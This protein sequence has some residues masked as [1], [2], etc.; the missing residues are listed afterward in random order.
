M[1]RPEQHSDAVRPPRSHSLFVGRRWEIDE[2]RAALDEVANGAGQI[3]LLAGE[4]G[5][6]KTRLVEEIVASV[7]SHDIAVY[8]GR[9]DDWEGS[10]AYWPWSQ[11]LSPIVETVDFETLTSWMGG[12]AALLAQIVPGVAGPRELS[13]Q[14]PPRDSEQ[15]RFELFSAVADLVRN[16]AD[17]RPLILV[18][19]DLHWADTPSLELFRFLVRSIRDARIMLLATYRPSEAGRDT[20]LSA[21]LGSMAREHGHRR[22]TLHGL[23]RDEVAAFVSHS[24]QNSP[25]KKLVDA[26][27]GTVDGNPFFMRE[28]VRL[29]IAES[30]VDPARI[31]TLVPE[32]VRDAV[33]QRVCRLPDSCSSLLGAASVI[34]REF[35][36]PILASASMT[37]MTDVIDGIEL[38]TQAGLIEELEAGRYRFS[39]ALVQETL[40]GDLPAA[41]RLAAHQR[42]GE[43]LE[44]R[45]AGD[46]S[47][48]YAVLSRHFGAAAPIG[49]A[50]KAV[51]YAV[52]AADAAIAQH[53][54]ET[55]IEHYRIALRSCDM[56]SEPSPVTRCDLLLLLGDAQ[57]HAGAGRERGHISGESPDAIETYW[58]AAKLAQALG[59][60]EQLAHAALGIAGPDLGSPQSGPEGIELMETALAE[61][62]AADSPLRARLLARVAVDTA[63]LW[64]VG[65]LHLTPAQEAGIVERSDE[66]VEIARRAGDAH[67]LAYALAARR[68]AREGSG[69]LDA[70]L[71]D[72]EKMLRL[73]RETNNLEITIW[74]LDQKYDVLVEAGETAAA[75][76]VADEREQLGERYRTPL[77]QLHMTMMRSGEALRSGRFGDT[78]E[79]IH[80]ATALWP[81]TAMAAFQLATLRR[82]QDRIGEV[83]ELIRERQALRPGTPQWRSLLV[84]VEYELD[85]ERTAQ[86]TFDGIAARDFQ[87]IHRSVLWLRSMA[88]LAEAA[89]LLRDA[90]RAILLYDMLLPFEDRNLFLRNSDF[91]GGSVAYYLGLLAMTMERWN[92]AER[93]L[94]D[95]LQKNEAWGQWPYAAH[96]RHAW[97]D[98]LLR[99][100]HGVDRER[101][102]ALNA[103][104]L[105]AAESMGMTRLARLARALADTAAQGDTEP[106]MDARHGLSARELDVL[107]LIVAGRT[108]REIAGALF[109]S[110]RTVGSHVSS[111]LSKLDASSRTEATARAIRDGL[112]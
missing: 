76:R 55:A 52:R 88:Y 16:V 39:H 32:S 48:H 94:Q 17:G 105:E 14:L 96:A 57:T 74:G 43:A 77:F 59:L 46:A 100:G 73:A 7:S 111:I 21:A 62:T 101:A 30:D 72:A 36:L 53:A 10:P 104:A 107:R 49:G 23:S 33:R 41:R 3:V 1:P 70:W 79:L 56:L 15:A 81:R 47:S 61:S 22:L 5:I 31:S 67:T 99:R 110:P 20:P 64:A 83:V 42:T 12:S 75:L 71:A 69:D 2:L 106:G 84:L 27:V 80:K 37:S 92:D 18:V 65:S 13:V 86:A 6:G 97:A 90:R 34:G 91:T 102:L 44:A 66:A 89:A 24:V 108:D 29:L 50:E 95:G 38:A 98:M 82:E 78:E 19:D 58:Q 63:R 28:L 54:W 25:D 9:C 51:A 68:M 35:S 85:G 112:V 40:Y 87:D 103:G 4:P 26:I 60:T 45:P 8:W 93:H 109:I 11:I